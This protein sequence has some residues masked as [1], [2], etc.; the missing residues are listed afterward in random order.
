MNPSLL[1]LIATMFSGDHLQAGDHVQ[2][3]IVDQRSRTYLVHVPRKYDPTVSTPIVL[4]FHGA[5]A[6]G[7][8]TVPFTGLNGK[9][10]EAGF[11]AVYP[12]GTGVGEFYTWNAGGVEGKWA[13]RRPDDVKFV[14]MLLEDLQKKVNVDP[15]RIYATGMSNGGMM[16]YRLA[17]EL[18]DK[19]AAIAPVAG[20]M[21]IATATP[22]RPVPLM[23]F[24]GT[25]D[26]IVPF[27]GPDRRVPQF[28]TFKSV[29]E[30]IEIWRRLDKAT[31][32][33]TVI[34]L[35]DASDDGTR[36]R[37]HKYSPSAGGAE[38]NLIEIVGGG[39]TWPGGRL[40]LDLLGI[41]TQDISANDLM[42]SFF[43][44]HQ[45][46]NEGEQAPSAQ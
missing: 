6:N 32:K 33:E 4:I 31:E 13:E 7:A 27:L 25:K 21:A 12:N 40:R 42:W 15:K 24:H 35:M 17:A 37:Q 1:I 22:Q 26:T 29:P 38:V 14:A 34:E 36:V 5:F 11:I 30:T 19:I 23:H 9:S 18:S 43:E 20:T 39:H 28:L 44:R 8:V 2:K 41:T 45:L 10:E 46:P 16:C 3:L